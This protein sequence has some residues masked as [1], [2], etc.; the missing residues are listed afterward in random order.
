MSNKSNVAKV[1]TRPVEYS[2]LLQRIL[3][4]NPLL[5]ASELATKRLGKSTEWLSK[6]LGLVRIEDPRLQ[7]LVNEGKI[8]LSNAHALSKLP[9]EEQVNFA[10]RA[11][12]LSPGEFIPMAVGRV[13]QIKDDRR[14]GRDTKPEEF[15]A[16]PHLRK[17]SDLKDERAEPR[18]GPQLLRKFN[19]TNPL[20]AWRLAVDWVLNV[21][22]DSVEVRKKKDDDRKELL[23]KEK[24]K[25]SAERAQQR[26]QEAARKQAELETAKAE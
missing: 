5:T 17:M 21:D 11:M 13:K 14:K 2:K 18:T 23:K 1:E 4:A 20:D 16:V 22:P 3:T 6:M 8:N 7:Q 15:V 19:V 9:P 12:T 10:D 26:A 24:L 25:K